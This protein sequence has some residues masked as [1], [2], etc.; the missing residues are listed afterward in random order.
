[1]L[2]QSSDRRRNPHQS[3]GTAYSEAATELMALGTPI[4]MSA[5]IRD[6]WSRKKHGY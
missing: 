3:P 6:E 4:D 2:D 1:M 5:A